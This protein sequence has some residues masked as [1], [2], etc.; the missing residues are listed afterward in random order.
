MDWSAVVLELFPVA[1]AIY[2]LDALTWVREGWT[3]LR[4]PWGRRWRTLAPGVRLSGL[5]PWARFAAFR[6]RGLVFGA[7]SLFVPAQWREAPAVQ[8]EGLYRS[9]PYE[10]IRSVGTSG[11]ELRVNGERVLVLA[12]ATE[13]KAQ[14][15]WVR[16]LADAGEEG[17]EEVLRKLHEESSSLEAV[18]EAW[19]RFEGALGPLNALAGGTA[20]LAFVLI[21][22]LAY[23]I[24]GGHP[25]LLPGLLLALAALSTATLGQATVVFRRHVSDRTPDVLAFVGPLLCFPLSAVQVPAHLS[26]HVLARFDP[27]AVA[28]LLLGREEGSELLGRE[29]ERIDASLAGV[30]DE[31]FAHGLRAQRASVVR[32]LA[33]GDLGAPAGATR[34]RRSVGAESYCPACRSEFVEGVAVCGECDVAVRPYEAK[35]DPATPP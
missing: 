20:G 24:Q 6:R 13:A 17:R 30:G 1:C 34:P 35:R 28:A 18:G 27:L 9:L 32:L 29:I 15:R 23:G 4:A 2:V 22:A 26:R 31:E 21:P 16:H 14:A 12:T 3:A 10:T 7:R 25:A 19:R 11:S 5:W 8:R 33:I